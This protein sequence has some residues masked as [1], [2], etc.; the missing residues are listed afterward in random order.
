[1]LERKSV[2]M[3]F[4]GPVIDELPKKYERKKNTVRF[5]PLLFRVGPTV[6]MQSGRACGSATLSWNPELIFNSKYYIGLSFGVT[7]LS[8]ELNESFVESH[9]QIMF[10]RMLSPR[11]GA[12]LGGGI[13][14]WSKH[15]GTYPL[16]SGGL[17]FHFEQKALNVFDRAFLGYSG[18]LIPQHYTHEFRLGLGL[19]F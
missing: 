8:N 11:V 16:L 9:A 2:T 14:N 19:S 10:G 4:E 13:Q 3:P 5:A 7:P 17:V 12:E 15:G 6:A 1:M 18:Y